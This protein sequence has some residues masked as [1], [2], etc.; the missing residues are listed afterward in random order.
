MFVLGTI[1]LSRV[2]LNEPP[3][4]KWY[5]IVRAQKDP[6]R[7]SLQRWLDLAVGRGC[8]LSR[9]FGAIGHHIGNNTVES[10]SQPQLLSG[11]VTSVCEEK[12]KQ[13]G[14]RK[15]NDRT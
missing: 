9:W 12:V 2:Y 1:S 15:W 10:L 7:A 3:R 14:R 4:L 11:Q 5:E 8:A 13:L 6:D